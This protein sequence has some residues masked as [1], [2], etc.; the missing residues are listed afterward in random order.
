[1]KYRARPQGSASKLKTWRDGL[2][3][4][5]TIATLVRDVRPLFF[6]SVIASVLAV[7]GFVLGSGVIVEYMQTHLVPRLP[8]ALL[9]TGLMLLASLH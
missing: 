8:T 3:I 2:L 4:L 7:T 9:A 5:G 1:M 6:F